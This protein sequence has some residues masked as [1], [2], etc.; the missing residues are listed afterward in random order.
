M[1]V[2]RDAKGR[3]VIWLADIGD[4]RSTWESVRVHRIREPKVLVDSS[5]RAKT[6]DVRFEDRPHD[7]E[8]L[9]VAPDSSAMWIV[10]KQLARGRLYELPVPLSTSAV[11][12][13]RFVQKERGLVTDGAVS[14]DGT[15]Y[16]LR[17]YVDATTFI[18]QPP[19]EQEQVIPLPFQVQGEA[20]AWTADSRG[21]LVA[22]ERDRRIQVV[23]PA[24]SVVTRTAAPPSTPVAAPSEA[25]AEKAAS[26]SAAT[27]DGN[28]TWPVVIGL[29]LGAVAVLAIAEWRRRVSREG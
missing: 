19:G 20:I 13:A 2:A 10:T 8:A 24:E 22:R 21:W 5:V 9:L 27:S 14:P 6:F 4:N 29:A 23:M 25:S 3:P 16:V 26:T 18:G 28:T 17:D 7:A 11:N 15:R 12:T 1:A